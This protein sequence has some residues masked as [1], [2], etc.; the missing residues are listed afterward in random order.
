MLKRPLQKILALSL[1]GLLLMGAAPFLANAQTTE[2]TNAYG[3]RGY[4]PTAAPSAW[5][6]LPNQFVTFSGKGFAPFETVTISGPQGS[7][8]I[9]ANQN[10]AFT[11]GVR[12]LAPY[13]AANTKP[14]FTV[15]GS[16]SQSPVSLTLSVGT[17]YP[18]LNPAAYYVY[19]GSTMTATAK[20]FA[21]TEPVWLY[22]DGVF[23]GSSVATKTGAVTWQFTTPKGGAGFTLTAEG[24][25]SGTQSSRVITF[26]LQ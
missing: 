25:W 23:V 8:N 4:Y 13:S 6:L 18:V 19:P 22:S 9:K 15:A 26:A 14:S 5:Y 21:P 1:G 17:F 11:G 24:Q 12:Y 10:G 2:T 16:I 3:L 20:N 7:V